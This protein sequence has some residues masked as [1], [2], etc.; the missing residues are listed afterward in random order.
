M[1]LIFNHE[2]GGGISRYK[3]IYRLSWKIVNFTDYLLEKRF[4][5]N[6][7]MGVEIKEKKSMIVQILFF[8]FFFSQIMSFART[9]ES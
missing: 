2:T 4:S 7:F 9:A 3:H 5:V 6:G 8:F 1:I